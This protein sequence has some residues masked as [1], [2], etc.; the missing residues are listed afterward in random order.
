LADYFSF[1]GIKSSF[2]NEELVSMND[3]L[4]ERGKAIEDLFFQQQDQKL[5]EALKNQM[6]SKEDRAELKAAS[7]I[8][9]DAVLDELLQMGI[10]AQ[11]IAAVGLIPLI[12]VAWADK[13]MEP[14]ESAAILKAAIE[15]GIAS[16]SGS[17]SLIKTWMEKQPSDELLE[18]WKRYVATLKASLDG[19]A[20]AQMKNAILAR[21]TS[22]A[23]AAGGFLGMGSKV[24]DAEK[25]VI[26]DLE[27]AF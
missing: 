11:T 4:H 20:F 18:T 5:I 21:A 19:A 23:E 26:A 12:F 6:K 9:D 2:R 8:E 7:G 25:A 1:N 24:S 16:T 3:P 27:S 22:V 13:K 14:S 15:S 10:S 17:Y